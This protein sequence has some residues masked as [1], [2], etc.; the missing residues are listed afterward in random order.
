[1]SKTQLNVLVLAVGS[2]LGQSI[3][4][5]LQISKLSINIHVADINDFAAG[6]YFSRVHSVILPYVKDPNYLKKL[7][8]YI[9]KNK[10]KAIFPVISAEH[11]F[12]F[13]N[14]KYF[15]NLGV[16][17][18]SCSEDVFHLCNDKFNSMIQL[19]KFNLG[20]P[21]TELC[22]NNK[23]IDKFLIRN[24]FPVFLKPRYG[25]SS[26]NI[27][28]VTGRRQLFSIL[29]AF[30]PDYFIIQAFLDDSSDYTAGVY[31]SKDR[32]F[33][34]TLLIKRQLKFGLSYSGHIF[35]DNKLSNYC[36]KIA[37]KISSYYSINVQFKIIKGTPYTYEINPRL[38]STT[39]IRA[40]FGFNEP[41]MMLHE[42]KGLFSN[43]YLKKRCGRFTRYWE[44][45]YI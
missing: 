14:A 40:N 7:T 21:D 27:F 24:N 2:P 32:K 43:Y 12:F 30:S 1:M 31:I 42:A 6:F 28:K 4:K 33:R 17:I 44:E 23:K 10:I 25:A 29:K 34:S 38:S 8:N 26:T 19:R 22:I 11:I 35:E 37:D 20:A 3:L 9:Q 41:D 16:E 18:L 5:A 39:S 36:L 45:H 15:K 13:Q